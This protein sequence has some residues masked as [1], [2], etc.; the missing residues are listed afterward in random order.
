MRNPSVWSWLAVALGLALRLYHFLRCPAVWQ[1]EAALMINVLELDYAQMFGP[2]LKAEAA[3]PLFLV[4]Q[5]AIIVLFGDSE[6]AFRFI[7]Y[8]VSTLGM[9]VFA[10]LM[11]LVRPGWPAVLGTLLYACSDR[12][13]WH[14]CEAKPY[15]IDSTLA[16]IFA[17][18]FVRSEHWSLAWRCLPLTVVVPIA[19]WCSFPFC[20]V[21]GGVLLGLLPAIRQASS[22]GRLSYLLLTLAVFASFLALGLGPAK[23]QRHPEMDACWVTH[24]PDYSKPWL[25]PVWV[26]LSTFEVARYCFLPIGQVMI[27][28]AAIGGCQLLRRGEYRR[29]AVA[30]TPM[31][32]TL[33][34]ALLKAYPYGSSRLEVFVTGGLTWLSVEGFVFLWHRLASRSQWLALSLLI[35]FLVPVALTLFYMVSPW[36]RDA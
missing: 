15:I 8:F 13:L 24:F 17:Y 18:W 29:L 2:L 33:I 30:I 32:L 34:A 28:F 19:M 35:W 12:L 26:I 31:V 1:D 21:I 6:Y 10:R 22:I 25:V 16:V 5:K 9:V 7:P 4:L 20:F 14:S 23:A 3:P 36:P 27:L 11:L